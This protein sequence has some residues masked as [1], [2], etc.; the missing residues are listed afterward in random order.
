MQHKNGDSC[1]RKTVHPAAR[2]LDDA[3]RG[4]LTARAFAR[5]L[6][7]DAVK[8]TVHKVAKQ[9]GASESIYESAKV[10]ESVCESVCDELFGLA[11]A[12]REEGQG[13][14]PCRGKRV[15]GK[16]CTKL[17]YHAGYCKAHQDQRRAQEAKR[18]RLQAY[19]S[20]AKPA[21][22]DSFDFLGSGLP[23][24]TLGGTHQA[25]RAAVEG[26]PGWTLDHFL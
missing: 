26:G 10:C 16:S 6:V 22:K 7:V 25:G 3:L 19:A 12:T 14:D 1:K 8:R 20:A 13:S 4:V 24:A 18:R 11:N 23:V 2:G 15:N 17:A 9:I 21:V 5:D